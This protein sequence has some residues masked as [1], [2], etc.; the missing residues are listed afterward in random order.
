MARIDVSTWEQFVTAWQTS[1][2][3][4]IIEVNADLD[5]N[6]NI[7]NAMIGDTAGSVSGGIVTING[8]GHTVYNLAPG[9]S[10]SVMFGSD[11]H[12][13]EI[14]R[15][16][17]QNINMTNSSGNVFR[18]STDNRIIAFYDCNIQGRSVTY[19]FTYCYLERCTM[20]LTNVGTPISGTST[21]YNKCWIYLNNCRKLW[22]DWDLP[23]MRKLN[24]CYLKGS[25]VFDGVDSKSDI[26]EYHTN[27]CI[28]VSIT[29]VSRAVAAS[30]YAPTAYG[31]LSIINLSKLPDGTT[32][33]TDAELI[34]VTDTQM[35]DAEYL[36]GIGFDIVPTSE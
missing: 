18:G 25:I 36:A 29:S 6:D 22:H 1:T 10:Q 8:N 32:A 30:D 31:L 2:G 17:F 13:H 27:C 34:A 9:G 14:N 28:N 4:D 15:L 5:V 19:F 33:S 7:P 20:T 24:T 26:I 12:R 35:K 3:G 11:Y 21:D 23:L 16:N